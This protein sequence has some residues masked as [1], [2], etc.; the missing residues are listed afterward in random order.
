MTRVLA[1]AVGDTAGHVLPALAIA[2][3]YAQLVGEIDVRFFAAGEGAGHW[4]IGKAGYPL[5]YVPGS[6]I[7]RTSAGQQALALWR[8]GR[9]IVRARGLLRQHGARLVIGTGG[10]GSASA[11]LAARTLGLTTA[12][13]EPNVEPGLAN[14]LLGR[15]VHRA[16][17]AFQET[18][19]AFPRG[20]SLVTG[21]PIRGNLSTLAHERRAPALPHLRILVMSGSRGAQF[22][23]EHVPALC[24]LL[25]GNGLT[26]DVRHQG[27]A[28]TA[29]IEAAYARLGIRARVE[30]FISD[31][32]AAL[33]NADLAITRAGAGTIAEL[34]TAGIPALLVPLA[35]AA[36]DHQAA[37]AAAL[38]ARGAALMTRESD[39][40]TPRIAD[41]ML[42]LL[43]HDTGWDTMSAAMF[44][45]AREDGA[46][47]IVTDCE[48]LME[49]R[50]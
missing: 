19:A 48:A 31:M 8:T 21:V 36:H 12:L 6:Q 22:L 49:G 4:L 7:A 38:V 37:N 9:G 11:L 35:D 13:V 26:L 5:H 50:W 20:T 40:D 14:K 18:T 39:W 16:Y 1:L 45:L 25:A 44:A 42:T 24:S 46:A 47:R 30:S 43:R 34:A 15:F 28:E 27:G 10:Y 32:P 3:A 33:A 29:T 41:Q 23:G 2:E 17:V